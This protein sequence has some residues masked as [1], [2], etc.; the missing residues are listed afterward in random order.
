MKDEGSDTPL[1]HLPAGDQPRHFRT[2]LGEAN[3]IDG[4]VWNI[5]VEGFRCI[6]RYRN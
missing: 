4:G 5:A 2:R 6:Y 1:K 3:A